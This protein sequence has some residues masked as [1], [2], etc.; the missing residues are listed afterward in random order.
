[1]QDLAMTGRISNTT[2]HNGHRGRD[3][4]P[5]SAQERLLF[6]NAM[7][8]VQALPN[9]QRRRRPSPPPPSTRPR[10]RE[11]DEQA[12]LAE[13]LDAPPIDIET[14][15]NLAWR[16]HGVQLSVLRKLRRGHYSCQA[17]LDLHGLF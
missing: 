1:M 4:E 12:V 2:G 15:D 14:G 8:D 10:Q 3:N 11:A 9:R 6:R 17:E 16:R 7:G 5:V 13:L